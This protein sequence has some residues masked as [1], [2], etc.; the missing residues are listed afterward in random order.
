MLQQKTCLALGTFFLVS[1]LSSLLYHLIPKINACVNCA[2]RLRMG[3][4]SLMSLGPCSEAYQ[5][6]CRRSKGA[7]NAKTWATKSLASASIEE[8]STGSEGRQEF[9]GISCYHVCAISQTTN[10]FVFFIFVGAVTSVMGCNNLW[11]SLLVQSRR[12]IVHLLSSFLH[13]L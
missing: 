2:W 13:D 6:L 8:P 1:L 10:K 7:T 5:N 11:G 4:V 3:N 9:S 12:F